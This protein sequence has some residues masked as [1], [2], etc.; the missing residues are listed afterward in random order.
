MGKPTATFKCLLIIPIAIL[1]YTQVE[2]VLAKASV[3]LN[4]RRDSYTKIIPM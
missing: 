2:D 1:F 3:C 4:P